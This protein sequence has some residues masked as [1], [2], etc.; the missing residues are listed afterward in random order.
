MIL[1]ILKKWFYKNRDKFI[2][3]NRLEIFKFWISGANLENKY[4]C[5]HKLF[6]IH[7]HT[8]YFVN[9]GKLTSKTDKVRER[10]FEKLT[11]IPAGPI[12][13]DG[14]GSPAGP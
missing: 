8:L 6:F 2:K 13:P 5:I 10:D 11:G 9:I 7:K 4:S 12:S 1:L 14:P 3:K